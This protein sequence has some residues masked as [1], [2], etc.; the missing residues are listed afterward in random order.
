M[1]HIQNSTNTP[2]YRSLSHTRNAILTGLLAACGL[3]TGRSCGAQS[4]VED[5][6]SDPALGIDGDVIYVYCTEDDDHVRVSDYPDWENYILVEILDQD[7]NLLTTEYFFAPQYEAVIVELDGG[8]DG[9]SNTTDFPEVVYGGIGNDTMYGGYG[10]AGVD[11][12]FG[13]DDDDILYGG[14]DSNTIDGGLG[15][16]YLFGEGGNDVVHGRDGNDFLQDDTG[17][18]T[19]NGNNGNDILIGGVNTGADNMQNFLSGN[20]GADQFR[21]DLKYTS[22]L[23]NGKWISVP[24]PEDSLLDVSAPAGDTTF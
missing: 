7:F 16:D 23:V 22:I 13:E 8:Y 18:D 11:K 14:L 1:S 21:V 19:L 12:L 15:G 9:F 4:I 6:L 2:S 24:S 20:Q 3:L 5:Y 17:I 10:E